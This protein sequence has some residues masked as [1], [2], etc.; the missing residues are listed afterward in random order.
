MVVGVVRE[1]VND[2]MVS[3]CPVLNFNYPHYSR[4][5]YIQA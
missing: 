3:H 5:L 1:S 2:I 4:R